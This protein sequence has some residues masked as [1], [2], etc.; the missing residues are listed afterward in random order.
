MTDKLPTKDWN[1]L[2][3]ESKLGVA[4]NL[5]AGWMLV[6]INPPYPVS[7]GS[8]FALGDR[9]PYT[10]KVISFVPPGSFGSSGRVLV[11]HSDTKELVEIFPSRLGLAIVRK[12]VEQA[13]KPQLEGRRQFI[14]IEE[15]SGKKFQDELNRLHGE[16]YRLRAS[17][18]GQLGQEYQYAGTYQ[19][20]MEAD[21]R[22]AVSGQVKSNI[23]PD[24]IKRMPR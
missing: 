10:G 18:V 17:S 2:C 24:L 13:A 19:A 4:R 7:Y 12:P 14:L 20:L 3:A 23:D 1:D 16:G 22:V 5:A 21:D 15:G 9:F 11:E 6:N 8:T